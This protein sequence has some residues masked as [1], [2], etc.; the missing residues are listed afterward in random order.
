MT[1]GFIQFNNRTYVFD[2]N[3]GVESINSF[4]NFPGMPDHVFEESPMSL[5]NL[6]LEFHT[7]RL[8]SNS[9]RKIIHI[10]HSHFGLSMLTILIS[11][12]WLWLRRPSK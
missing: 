4:S 2:Y 12:T 8:L 6:A 1:A 3:R 5:W 11:G 7:G 10:V 9:I